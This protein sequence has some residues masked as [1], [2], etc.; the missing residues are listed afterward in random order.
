M[1]VVVSALWVELVSS[2]GVDWDS[3]GRGGRW[4]WK[5]ET[6][7]LTASDP[8]GSFSLFGVL[9]LF[10]T[11]VDLNWSLQAGSWHWEEVK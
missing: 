1:L 7:E 4:F 10:S 9:A 2:G 3:T 11:S 6:W 5:S 8:R